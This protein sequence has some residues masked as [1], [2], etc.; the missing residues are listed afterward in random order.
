M[1]GCKYPHP[2]LAC[3]TLEPVGK[4]CFNT[5]AS[6]VIVVVLI[7]IMYN[8]LIINHYLPHKTHDSVN[9][10]HSLAC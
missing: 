3:I 4:Y 7:N 1:K 10:F 9:H 2:H 8:Q 6:S 5:F